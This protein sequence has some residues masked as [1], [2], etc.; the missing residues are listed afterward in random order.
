MTAIILISLYLSASLCQ[1]IVCKLA[2][3]YEPVQLYC[4]K[5]S[6]SV[7]QEKQ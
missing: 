4:S 5:H 6:N 3:L 2:I 1:N 7:K